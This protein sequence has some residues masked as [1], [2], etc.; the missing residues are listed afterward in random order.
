MC[1]CAFDL[2]LEGFSRIRKCSQEGRLA[3]TLDIFDLNMGLNRIKNTP[4]SSSSSSSS[5][6]TSTSNSSSDVNSPSEKSKSKLKNK[7]KDKEISKNDKN[8]KND[9]KKKSSTNGN[10]KTVENSST[11]KVR[12][13]GSGV[14]GNKTVRRGKEHVDEYI[15]A[16]Y[17]LDEGTCCYN[18]HTELNST[19]LCFIMLCH[20]MPCFVWPCLY[21]I[22]TPSSFSFP[23]FP[24]FPLPYPL[25]LTHTLFAN[26]FFSLLH[27]TT[28]LHP[29]FHTFSFLHPILFYLLLP[30]SD[31]MVWV[32]ENWRKYAYRH[33]LGLINMVL[34]SPSIMHMANTSKRFKEAVQVRVV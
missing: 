27:S 34:N 2:A 32:H 18:T 20:A 16:T 28:S 8:D 13:K 4:T 12:E 11:E 22:H 33:I 21:H 29:S 26:S 7:D 25:H 10:K 30:H 19:T 24:S 3:M 31:L 23:S 14:G 1:E 15:Q 5:T 9:E 6:L 17:L